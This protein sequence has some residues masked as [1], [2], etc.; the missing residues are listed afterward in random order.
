MHK[1]NMDGMVKF[2]KVL[3]KKNIFPPTLVWSRKYKNK[4]SYKNTI[5]I[6]SPFLYLHKMMEK[7]IFQ[8]LM[9]LA[10]FLLMDIAK[11]I[12]EF[13]KKKN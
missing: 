2:L 12:L 3:E 7:K 13:I 10:C 8:N 1:F 4:N 11:V 6:G 5:Q 9:V